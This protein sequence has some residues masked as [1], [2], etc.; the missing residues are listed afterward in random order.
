MA[1]KSKSRRNPTAAARDAT[2]VSNPTT[3]LNKISVARP[4][5]PSVFDVVESVVNTIDDQRTTRA[6]RKAVQVNSVAHRPVH[7]AMRTLVE[8][9]AVVSPEFKSV[10]CKAKEV[11]RSV[12]MAKRAFKVGKGGNARSAGMFRNVRCK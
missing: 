9:A 8:Q 12:L 4:L 3:F 7:H 2:D 6:F 5:M 11:R 10:V 1:T